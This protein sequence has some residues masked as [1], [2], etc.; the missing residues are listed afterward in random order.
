MANI[1]DLNCRS[2]EGGI[3]LPSGYKLV[4]GSRTIPDVNSSTD[5]PLVIRNTGYYWPIGVTN[6]IMYGSTYIT[7]GVNGNYSTDW[8]P[9]SRLCCDIDKIDQIKKLQITSNGV[10]FDS[11]RVVAWL[12]KG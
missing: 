9:V 2:G 1:I 3:K 8:S 6:Y 12:T 7:G 11:F 4:T 5:I 10:A